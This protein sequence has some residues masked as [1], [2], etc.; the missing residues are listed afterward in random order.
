MLRVPREFKN[1][2]LQT[3][4]RHEV[5]DIAPSTEIELF[6]SPS[7]V[8]W[9]GA[10]EGTIWNDARVN[11]SFRALHDALHLK[12]GIGF[13]PLEE[14]ELGRI[15]ASRYSGLLADLVYC[16]VA[17]Q[18]EHYLKTGQ[19]VIDQV[20]FTLNYLKQRGISL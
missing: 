15:Q 8:I 9:S 5:K 13:S 18:A 1:L 4:P 20:E 19:F 17:G 10:S 7:L 12:V 6:N 14:I 2:I 11:W 16:E 3:A